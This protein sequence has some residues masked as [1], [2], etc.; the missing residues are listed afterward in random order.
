MSSSLKREWHGTEYPPESRDCLSPGSGM[1]DMARSPARYR[2]MALEAMVVDSRYGVRKRK[3]CVGRIGNVRRRF[4]R[5]V[6]AWPVAHGRARRSP[7]FTVLERR[8]YG[9]TPQGR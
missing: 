5:C 8:P 4:S 6:E 1:V 9:A 7:R 3:L 2:G